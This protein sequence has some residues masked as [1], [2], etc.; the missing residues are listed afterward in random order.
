[1]VIGKGA[2][3]MTSNGDV[4]TKFM[5]CMADRPSLLTDDLPDF[6][7]RFV[8]RVVRRISEPDFR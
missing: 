5:V 8:F 3:V 7:K 2:A 1:M 6:F 4:Y